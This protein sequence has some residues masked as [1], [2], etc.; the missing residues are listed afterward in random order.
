MNR[1]TLHFL[2]FLHLLC[3]ALVTLLWSCT[4]SLWPGLECRGKVDGG[5]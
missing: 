5:L 1:S 4:R 3:Q 2:Y